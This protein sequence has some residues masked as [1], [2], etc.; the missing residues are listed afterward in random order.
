MKRPRA[1]GS[2]N[3]CKRFVVSAMLASMT[4]VSA[5]ASAQTPVYPVKPVRFIA[6]FAPGGLVDVLARSL[7]ERQRNQ[8]AS[9]AHHRIVRRA[10]HS[11]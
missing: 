8:R 10:G 9:L 7:S 11:R 6:P 3:R 4:I 1:M 5:V 2:G